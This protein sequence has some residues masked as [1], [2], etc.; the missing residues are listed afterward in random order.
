MVLLVKKIKWANLLK[1][2]HFVGVVKFLN[3]EH[4]FCRNKNDFVFFFNAYVHLT[5]VREMCH[6]SVWLKL[7]RSKQQMQHY[8]HFL[9]SA[10]LKMAA[11]NLRK[12][13]N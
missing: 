13:S 9:E 7:S 10:P 1:N 3:S 5:K 12:H 6:E 2:K 8:D 11:T 4:C